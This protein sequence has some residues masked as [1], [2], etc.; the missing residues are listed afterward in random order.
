M[1]VFILGCAG[2]SLL[3]C[4]CGEW[5]LLS[6]YNVLAS[7]CSGFSL[8]RALGLRHTSFSSCGSQALEHKL[9]SCGIRV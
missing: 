7:H 9:N 8:F 5:G 4:G 2:S 1:Y 3:F 6:S